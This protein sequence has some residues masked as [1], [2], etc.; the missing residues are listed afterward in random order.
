MKNKRIKAFLIDYLITALIQSGL[1]F[2][3]MILIQK[4]ILNINQTPLITL[5]IT[6]LSITYLVF[7]DCIGSRSVGK[8]IMKLEIINSN[9]N[10]ASFKQRL[11]RNLTMYILP[12]VI[13][14]YLFTNKT[15]Y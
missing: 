4:N 3:M 11:I 10:P 1:M 14:V 8:K 9:N 15:A 6:Y 12:I 2:L 5:I 7:R 13:L